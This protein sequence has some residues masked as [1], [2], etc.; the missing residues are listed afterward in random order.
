MTKRT[1]DLIWMFENYKERGPP[2]YKR[3][4]HLCAPPKLPPSLFKAS[5]QEIVET[6]TIRVNSSTADIDN[7]IVPRIKKCL[8]RTNYSNTLEAVAK[9]AFYLA[10]QL[11]ERYNVSQAE[12][13]AHE[14]PFTQR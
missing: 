8:E 3:T 14:P 10:S 6:G 2:P 5:V 7:A 13:L 4:A 1:A 11:I 9:A 12:V